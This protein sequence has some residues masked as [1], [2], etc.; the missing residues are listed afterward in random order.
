MLG[1]PPVWLEAANAFAVVA[2]GRQLREIAA[3]GL[4]KA[5]QP[6]RRLGA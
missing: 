5:I 2:T 3:S 1:A 4:V 6:Y